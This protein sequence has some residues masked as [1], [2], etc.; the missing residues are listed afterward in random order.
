MTC[1]ISGRCY[2]YEFY[3]RTITYHSHFTQQL[4]KYPKIS[5]ILCYTFLTIFCFYAFT[6][7]N[8]WWKG[9][10]CRPWSGAVWYGSALFAYS[11]LSDKLVYK[12]LG[13]LFSP[14]Q[15][16]ENQDTAQTENYSC[17]LLPTDVIKL[18][19][20]HLTVRTDVV[21]L[22]TIFT[23]SIQKDRPVQTMLTLIRHAFCSVWSRYAL[24]TTHLTVFRHVYR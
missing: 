20:F 16:G 19:I 10:Q 23:L 13:H 4:N 7:Q 1:G 24:F 15:T 21:H 9:K 6:P 3:S 5:Y 14:N 17:E 8:I 18:Y 22:H 12:M 2:T 11:N